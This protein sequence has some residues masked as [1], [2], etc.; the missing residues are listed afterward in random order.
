MNPLL[1]LVPQEG[2]KHVEHAINIDL[3]KNTEE[4]TYAIARWILDSVH[5]LLDLVGLEKHETLVTVLYAVIVFLVS[6]AVGRIVQWLVTTILNKIGP[7]VKS[8]FYNYLVEE[9]FFSRLGRI[10][11]ALVFLIFIEFTL[12]SRASLASWLTRITWIY[13]IIIICNALCTLADSIWSNIN[14]RANKKHLPLNGL[15]QLVKL[16]IWIV[17]VIVIVAIILDKSPASLLAGLG[18]FAAVLML[19]F[20]DSILGVVAGVQLSQNDSLHV[21]DWIAVPGADANGTVTEV[22]LTAVK[23]ENWDKT[24]STLPPYSLVSKGFKNYRNMSQS[25]TRRICRSYY[26]DADSV[27]PL[28]DDMLKEYAEIPLLKDWI[29]QKLEERTKGITASINSE[30]GPQIGSIDTNLGLFRA[31]MTFWL[32]KNP[33][34]SHADTCFVTTLQ[35]TSVGI[36]LQLYCFT[37]TSSWLPYEGVQA[38]VFEHMAVMLFK[39]KLY[40]FEYP[41]GRDEIIDGYL[42][43]G[44]NPD[45]IFGM[46]YPFFRGSGTPQSPA[47]PPAGLYPGSA[48]AQT[49]APAAASSQS[50]GGPSAPSSPAGNSSAGAEAGNATPVK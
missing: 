48:P 40:T 47:M 38:A 25:N 26:I 4:T 50:E 28:T 5:W 36:P 22:G 6:V 46:P 19:V 23:V 12:T 16:I 37:A 29:A 42:S 17:A 8:Q 32:F 45:A 44:K 31:Y 43:P 49:A 34:I 15:V 3:G 9:K 24:I 20:K 41:S 1:L 35:Q 33:N 39:F 13:F 2:A 27:V 30:Y 18:A 10:I 11:P 21:G 7:H 14:K